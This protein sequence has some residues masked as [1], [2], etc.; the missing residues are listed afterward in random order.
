MNEKACFGMHETMGTACGSSPDED[1]NYDFF[2]VGDTAPLCGG[3]HTNEMYLKA[4][5]LKMR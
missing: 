4:Q 5:P 1:I 2:R 3:K